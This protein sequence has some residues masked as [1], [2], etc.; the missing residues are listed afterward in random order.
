M[1]RMRLSGARGMGY[2]YPEPRK[3]LLDLARR[4]LTEKPQAGDRFAGL[5]SVPENLR[6]ATAMMKIFKDLMENF[7]AKV[8]A[9]APAEELKQMQGLLVAMHSASGIPVR[10]P[11]GMT[12]LPVAHRQLLPILAELKRRNT[13][14]VV[15]RAVIRSFPLGE[16]LL[17]LGVAE[18]WAQG[19]TGKG[20]KIAVID[21]GVDFDHPE[22]SDIKNPVIENMTRDRGVHTKGGHGTPMA[23]I[24]HAIAP[25]A[26]IQSYQALPNT[27][28]LVGVAL[29]QDET[30]KAVLAAMDKAKANGANIISMSL[31]FP[32]AY[33]NDPVALKVAELTAAG[34]VVIVSAGNEGGA[35]PK[36]MQI[37]SP[38]SSPDAI[39]IGAV[40]YHGGMAGFTSEG[41]VYNPDNGT[42][43]EKPDFYAPGV[44]IKAAMQLPQPMYGQEPVPYNPVSGTSPAAPHVTGVVALMMAAARAAGGD[45]T[46]PGMTDAVREG[47]TAGVRRVGR[48]PIVSDAAKAVKAFVDRLTKPAV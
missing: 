47:L 5:G 21:T 22:F 30:V 25:D 41:W 39:A 32:M 19:L 23:S 15:V 7:S 34:I 10:T 36:G 1:K 29:S 24:V 9:G 16:S 20:V 35:L 3:A 2:D 11:D 37:R 17:R 31:G 38:A 33:A 8:E 46:T 6:P 14:A 18:L 43:T 45:I 48:L 27:D 4:K 12:M 40:D 13:E 44:N 26:E 42:A 28:G